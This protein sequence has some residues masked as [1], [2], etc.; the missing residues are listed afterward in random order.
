MSQFKH[1]G[2][3]ERIGLALSG[4]GSRAIA[5]HLGCLRAL[6]AEGILPHIKTISAVSGGSIIA[7]LYCTHEGSFAEFESAVR[8]V[9]TEGFAKHAV[10]KALTTREGISALLCFALVLVVR[11]AGIVVS[12]GRRLFRLGAKVRPDK[13]WFHR[14]AS[15]TTILRRVYSDV[16]FDRK[17]FADLRQ[18]RPRLIIVACELR[19]KTAFY[20][21]QDGIGSYKLGRAAPGRMEIAHAVAASAAFPGLL[22]ALDEYLLLEKDGQSRSHR[23]ILTDGGVYDNLGIAPLWPDRDP[24]I[25]LHAEQYDTI[26]ACRAGYGTEISPP[27]VFWPSRMMAVVES[28]HARAQNFATNRLYDLKKSGDVKIFILPYLGQDD[29]KL[30]GLP[31]DFVR[32]E[33][34]ANYPTDFS[35]MSP[36]WIDKLSKRG[37]QVTRA[38]LRQHRPFHKV[39]SAASHTL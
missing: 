27:P 8:K 14:F 21:A 16:L 31:A 7:A 15:R 20:F 17:T 23:V 39:D 11:L 18:D 22:P 5:F 33:F 32:H 36:A 4:G 37:E 19:T 28:I 10:R 25:S 34:V 29:S 6:Q 24:T 9:L 1:D 35:A 26:I 13:T 2:G 3:A 12:L 30:A 38:L